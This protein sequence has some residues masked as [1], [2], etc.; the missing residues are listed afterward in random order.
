MFTVFSSF[1]KSGLPEG[2][3]L[4]SAA[5]PCA[6]QSMVFLQGCGCAFP[7]EV[8]ALLGSS[9]SQMRSA[10]PSRSKCQDQEGDWGAAPW[11]SACGSGIAELTGFLCSSLVAQPL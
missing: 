2:R 6:G 10:N 11:G 9:P 4:C 5:P 1:L 7:V 3:N 8:H